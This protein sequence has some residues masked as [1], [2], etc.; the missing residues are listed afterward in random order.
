MGGKGEDNKATVALVD[1]ALPRC[2]SRCL[3]C[4][5]TASCSLSEIEIGSAWEEA[6]AIV[7]L[8]L[9][10]EDLDFLWPKITQS[11]VPFNVSMPNPKEMRNFFKFLPSLSFLVTI[12]PNSANLTRALIPLFKQFVIRATISLVKSVSDCTG[13]VLF[14]LA[15]R[16]RMMAFFMAEGECLGYFVFIE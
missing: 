10:L 5:N 6:I 12:C 1:Q 2:A 15:N 7:D 13:V 9:R 11:S 4:N 3:I 14:A 8:G 16:R